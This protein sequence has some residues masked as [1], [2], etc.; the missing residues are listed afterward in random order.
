ME[1]INYAAGLGVDVMEISVI[2]R[3]IDD[4]DLAEL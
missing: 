4:E 3:A 2:A 1:V